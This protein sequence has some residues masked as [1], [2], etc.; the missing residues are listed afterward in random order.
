VN[1]PST[2]A[3][4]KPVPDRCGLCLGSIAGT[5]VDGRTTAGPWATMCSTCYQHVGCGLGPAVG[6]RYEQR[7]DGTWGARMTGRVDLS[8]G[9]LQELNRVHRRERDALR[10]R[11]ERAE[12]EV[13]RLLVLIQLDPDVRTALYDA[14]RACLDYSLVSDACHLCAF[15]GGAS[16]PHEAHCA[17]R[18]DER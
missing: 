11:A 13:A 17:L 16:I 14:G 8:I 1:A 5:F 10:D 2:R 18:E 9:A 15:D 3:T 4:V 7:P 6:Y 12:R